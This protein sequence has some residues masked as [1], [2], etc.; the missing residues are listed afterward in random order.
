MVVDD[1]VRNFF[2]ILLYTKR[3]LTVTEILNLAILFLSFYMIYAMPLTFVNEGEPK[4]LAKALHLPE[5]KIEYNNNRANS[6]VR[7]LVAHTHGF[8]LCMIL[9]Y[10]L[11]FVVDC[12]SISSHIADQWLDVIKVLINIFNL[13]GGCFIYLSFVTLYRTTLDENNQPRNYYGITVLF[14][15]AYI[16]SYV[17]CSMTVEGAKRENVHFIFSII[18]GM[19][20]GLAMA[21]LFGRFISLEYYLKELTAG[22][23]K[24]SRLIYN[25]SVI[26]ILPLYAL[27]QALYGVLDKAQS[28]LDAPQSHDLAVFKS[29]VFLICFVGKTFYFIVLFH[30]I[31]KKYL[32]VCLHMLLA[33]YRVPAIII[34][35]LDNDSYRIPH[36]PLTGNLTPLNGKKFNYKCIQIMGGDHS[37][38]GNC[39][40]E[41]LNVNENMFQ[42]QLTG[43]RTWRQEG[44]NDTIQHRVPFK[45]G[46]HKGIIFDDKTYIYRFTIT[47]DTEVNEGISFGKIILA[48][49]NKSI[50]AL[51]GNYY[52]NRGG[53]VVWGQETIELVPE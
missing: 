30:F 32:H 2:G 39:E 40:L 23:S 24:L 38:G 50:V 46:S 5:S 13:L 6:L 31:E 7:Q 47:A 29:I 28:H 10:A 18:C 26:F 14:A 45:W 17:I 48:D 8:I 49:D 35:S 4:M 25:Y 41:L 36:P 9:F 52:Q 44:G 11:F 33:N 27:A 42:W 15:I 1:K 43:E 19:Y 53:S 20:Q 16:I 37:H 3:I 21:L 34:R 22:E 51:K 12:E